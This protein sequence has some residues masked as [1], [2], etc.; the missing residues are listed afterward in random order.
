MRHGK[1]TFKVGRNGSHRRAM[2]ANMLKN[3]VMKDRI[4]TTPA[5]AKE[6][7]R[8]AD[9]LITLAKKDNL[10]AKRRVIGKLMIR[11]NEL[12]PKERR[13]AKEGNTAAYNEDRKVIGKLFGDLKSKYEDRAGGYTRIIHLGKR[14]GDNADMCFIEYI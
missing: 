10:A 8:H 3:L 12:T 4:E 1:H 11:Y 2:L 7:K 6:L 5:K 9:K 13:L 14:I